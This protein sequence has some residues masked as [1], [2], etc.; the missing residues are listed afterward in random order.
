MS[1][2]KLL[3]PG[4]AIYS[5]RNYTILL[6]EGRELPQD[7]REVL[8]AMRILLFRM[9]R[10]VENDEK[11]LKNLTKELNLRLAE[12]RALERIEELTPYTTD[13]LFDSMFLEGGSWGWKAQVF[14]TELGFLSL[15]GEDKPEL[16]LTEDSEELKDP[17]FPYEMIA[18]IFD[19]LM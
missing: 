5:H 3:N 19:L 6:P 8:D 10:E 2:R 16:W 7:R 4:E 11:Y 17:N 9:L 13:T 12:E 1:N 14:F 18:Q 15:T